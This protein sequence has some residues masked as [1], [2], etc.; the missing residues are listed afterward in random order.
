M[1]SNVA[2]A[3]PR[4]KS[5][6]KN[7]QNCRSRL[8]DGI[9]VSAISTIS[10]IVMGLIAQQRSSVSPK[11]SGADHGPSPKRRSKQG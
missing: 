4:K 1:H 2:I 10:N 11:R 9:R 8:S 5:P 3:I 7:D 6:G